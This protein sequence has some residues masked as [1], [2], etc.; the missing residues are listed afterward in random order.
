[1]PQRRNAVKRLRQDKKRHALNLK[2]KND[3]KKAVKQFLSLLD[4]KNL[5]EAK[6][7]FKQLTVKIDRAVFRK[8][9]HKNKAGRL[10]SRLS[11][12]MAKTA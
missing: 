2:H 11:K 10:K 8:T 1:M 6:K 7:F 5:E 3:L 9:I 12:R 4:A